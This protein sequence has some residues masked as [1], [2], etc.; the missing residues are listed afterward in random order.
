MKFLLYILTI[1]FSLHNII[2]SQSISK[3][4][5]TASMLFLRSNYSAK[6]SALGN[7]YT[8]LAEDNN[9]LFYNPA[10]LAS[11]ASDNFS[12]NHTEWFEQINFDNIYIKYKINEKF[13]I[14]SFISVA[15]TRAFF[16]IIFPFSNFPII[17][18]Q[19]P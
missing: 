1:F 10:G 16:K 8:G 2:W 15:K 11:V 14:G 12:L 17:P 5:G 19:C 9:A 13:V 7:S 6:I 18:K 4:A 3:N